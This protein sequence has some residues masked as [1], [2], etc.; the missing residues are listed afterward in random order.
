MVIKLCQSLSFVFKFHV[1]FPSLL[2]SS[3]EHLNTLAMST[4]E[5]VLQMDVALAAVILATLFALIKRKDLL[6][7]TRPHTMEL[8]IKTCLLAIVDPR[9]SV[10]TSKDEEVIKLFEGI[11]NYGKDWERVSKYIKSK[12]PN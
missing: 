5:K 6:Q 9:L 4:A 1:I 3:P 8:I 2:A 7:S 10:T 12:T 11:I